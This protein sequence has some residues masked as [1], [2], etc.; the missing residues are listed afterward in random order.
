[1]EVNAGAHDGL[2]TVLVELVAAWAAHSVE[3]DEGTSNYVGVHWNHMRDHEWRRGAGRRRR[4][5]SAKSIAHPVI[6]SLDFIPPLIEVGLELGG[7]G[8]H[9]D[10]RGG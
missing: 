9:G 6:H 10:E 5:R 1:V 8:S 4:G 3:L 2:A 7:Q